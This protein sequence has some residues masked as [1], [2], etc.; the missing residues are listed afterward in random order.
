MP[1]P[2]IL[3]KMRL[4]HMRVPVNFAKLLRTYFSK[5]TP[6][7]DCFYNDQRMTVW[8]TFNSGCLSTDKSGQS[9]KLLETVISWKIF[10]CNF[11]RKCRL[12]FTDRYNSSII[13]TLAV[14]SLSS[15][16]FFNFVKQENQRTLLSNKNIALILKFQ[17]FK[18]PENISKIEKRNL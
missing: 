5:K 4:Q 7:G 16:F 11:E 8:Q 3:L 6:S 17:I 13:D 10:L 1:M 2:A 15:L 18:L 12:N 14:K 9:I